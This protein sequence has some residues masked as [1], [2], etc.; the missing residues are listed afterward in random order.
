MAAEYSANAV[1]VVPVNGSVIFTEAP[2]PC[3]AGLI[4]HRDESGLFRLAS[5][6]AM[7]V[8]CNR[9]C[10]CCDFPTANY[11]VSFHANISVPED[12]AGT[13]EPISLALAIDGEIDPSSIM[14]VTVPLVSD[15]D[16]DNVGAHIIVSVPCICR[17]SSVSVRNVSTQPI[18]VQNANIVFDFAGV[19]R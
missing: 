1:Q 18:N 13:V 11:N 3:N 12:P 5:P 17:C 7:G 9:R 4:Y 8:C 14:T 15:T 2:V 16:G 19:R 6:S 10:C